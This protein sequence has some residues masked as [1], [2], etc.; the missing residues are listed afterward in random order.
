MNNHSNIDDAIERNQR[1]NDLLR[2]LEER[3]GEPAL[4]QELRTEF[5]HYSQHTKFYDQQL[6]IPNLAFFY[7]R[8]KEI[9]SSGINGK[10]GACFFNIKGFAQINV[11]L[12]YEMGTAVAARFFRGLQAILADDEYVCAV[13]SDYGVVVFRKPHQD[14]VLAYLAETPVVYDD[15]TRA[16]IN[17]RAV[18]GVNTDLGSCRDYLEVVA[19]LASSMYAARAETGKNVTFY[20]ERLRNRMYARQ[21]I[22]DMFPDSIKNREF[23][24]YYQPKVNLKNYRLCGAEALCR[25]RHNG[26]IIYP[27]DFIPVVE[28]NNTI[29]LL[30]F[31][32]LEH[33]CE[34]LRRWLEAG[35][36]PVQVSVNLSRCNIDNESLLDC[37]IDTI[38]HYEVPHRYL[39][40]ELTET[41]TD[42][43]ITDLKKLV[44]G[45]SDAGISTAV[46]DFG[47]GFS[48]L[49]IIK[50]LP[51]NV[52]KIDSSLLHG[53]ERTA[54]HNRQMMNHIISMVH[55]IGIDCIVEGV[56]T[57]DDI[58]LL[59]ENN[60]FMAQGF[61]FDKPLPV[62]IFEQRLQGIVL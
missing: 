35:L 20:D 47:Q 17:V 50:E 5:E 7:E 57:P 54:S 12:G 28:Q 38:D 23:L 37:I 36:N 60:C 49:N 14:S 52:L 42:V 22:E 43:D 55:D 31:Y 29:G 40:I 45:L 1:I 33:V 24:V 44:V 53:A 25:W 62:E 8:L 46:D 11:K 19:T 41:T 27:E 58:R 26:K 2:L 56:E 21:M 9:F 30:D 48:S 32:M 15:A 39:Q 6:N 4:L 59:K 16:V 10:F 51:W 61:Y 3:G 34:D 18:M 13:N